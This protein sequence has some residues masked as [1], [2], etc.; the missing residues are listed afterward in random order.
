MDL[1]ELERSLAGLSHGDEALQL[2]KNFAQQL[3]RGSRAE[4]FKDLAMPP[5]EYAEAL[6]RGVIPVGE[7]PFVLLQGDIVRTD[8][9]YH[10]G[11]RQV[12][13][14][15]LVANATCDLVPGRREF[16]TLL[17]ILPVR[18]DQPKVKE[19][20][21]E[22]LS[23]RSNRRMYLPPLSENLDILG[24][25]IELDRLAS[26]RLEALLLAE[27]VASL[28]LIGWRVLGSHLRAFFTRAGGSEV[29]MRAAYTQR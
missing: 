15:H 19:I 26:I 10:Q 20:L 28:S 16:A 6:A 27:R 18:R 13:Q 25:A 3:P 5:I 8:A 29:E 23:F 14:L 7:D 9:A 21:G 4:A 12:G 11:E 24:N 2:V 22:L 1:S 17:P